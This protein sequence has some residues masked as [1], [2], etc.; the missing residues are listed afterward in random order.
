MVA[1]AGMRIALI[2]FALLTLAA[3][4]KKDPPEVP[5]GETNTYPRSYPKQ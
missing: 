4:G 3:C 2:A 5:K 1:G